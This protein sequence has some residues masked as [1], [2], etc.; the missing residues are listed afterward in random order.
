[1]KQFLFVLSAIAALAAFAQTSCYYDNEVEQYGTTPCDTVA[2]SYSQDIL[3]IIQANCISC[4]AP[5]G[6]QE[7]SPFTSYDELKNYTDNRQIVERVNGVGGVMPPTGA[8]SE[9]NQLKIEAWVNAGA[10]EN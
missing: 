8:I 6:E 7:G 5:G 9:C 2:I 1:M 10:P 3:P 4:H